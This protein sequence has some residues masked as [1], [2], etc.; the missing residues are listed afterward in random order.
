MVKT[1]AKVKII[2]DEYVIVV[3]TRKYKT[4]G[5]YF[6]IDPGL[7]IFFLRAYFCSNL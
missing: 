1:K 4:N 2:I 5:E 3:L 7:E 6:E